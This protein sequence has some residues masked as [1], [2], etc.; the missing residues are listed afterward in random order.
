MVITLYISYTG[1]GDL[2]MGFQRQKQ[3]RTSFVAF[4]SENRVVIL[5]TLTLLSWDYGNT[6]FSQRGMHY[7]RVYPTNYAHSLRDALYKCISHKLCTQF[8]GCI[9]QEYIPQIMHT[10]WGMHYTRVYPTNY[11]HSLRD[12]LYK[13]IS[14]KLCTQFEGCI[15]QVYIPQIMHTVWG[16]HYARVYPTNYAHSLCF[17][18]L[19]SYPY[20]SGLLH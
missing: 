17:G 18:A 20:P 19:Q 4:H 15:I 2:H 9:I 5:T 12:A 16:M 11:A 8:E 13:C 7:V 6:Q 1:G 10:V 14:H 3:N